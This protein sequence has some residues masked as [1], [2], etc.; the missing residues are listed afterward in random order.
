MLAFITEN[1]GTIVVSA[2]LLAVV[3]AIVTGMVKKRR[4]G[5]SATC[6][7]G[8]EGCPSASMCHKH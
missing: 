6:G 8:C 4:S 7:C 1:L 3:A 5:K 2:V